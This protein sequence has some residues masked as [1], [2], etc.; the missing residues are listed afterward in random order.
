MAKNVATKFSLDLELHYIEDQ[1][2]SKLTYKLIYN[3]SG[4]ADFLKP[5]KHEVDLACD[6]STA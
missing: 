4:H 1:G 3:T 6:S 2:K 5:G